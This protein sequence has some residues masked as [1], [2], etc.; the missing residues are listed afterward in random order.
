M[1]FAD[2]HIHALF[3]V[4]DGPTSEREMQAMLDASYA[5]GTRLICFTPHCHPGLF[6]H[7]YSQVDIAFQ[8]AQSYVQSKYSDLHLFLGNELRF[9]KNCISLLSENHCRTINGTQYVL[10]DFPDDEDCKVM[11]RGL[12]RLLN[13]GYKPILAHAERY[14]RFHTDM[15]EIKE[16]REDGVMIQ[17]DA[18][19]ISG[20]F[21]FGCK[22]RSRTLLAM[23]YADLIASDAHGMQQRPPGLSKAYEII[24]H[25]YGDAYAEDLFW[26][27]AIQI[28]G[29]APSAINVSKN[30]E[31][32]L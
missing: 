19:S 25:K 2:I 31:K 18:L 26:H 6:G 27:H 20:A 29:I 9:G 13:A 23:H 22:R 30:K 21:G 12:S 15:R 7:N 4:D 16:L 28:I 1:Q 14:H 11:I 8:K 17:L 24:A 3:G 5:D 10:V 32:T